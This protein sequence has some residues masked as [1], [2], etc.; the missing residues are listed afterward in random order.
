MV[1]VVARPERD[2][3]VEAPL[4][5][6]LARARNVTFVEHLPDSDGCLYNYGEANILRVKVDN[7]VVRILRRGDSRIPWIDFDAAKICQVQ[8][9]RRILAQNVTNRLAPCLR[10]DQYR[11]HPR[12]R[13]LPAHILLE[14]ALTLD[15]IGVEIE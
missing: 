9:R 1:M 10:R 14:E 11:L 3:K 6:G 2:K 15:A 5:V 7:H 12:G 4:G 13:L 8:K